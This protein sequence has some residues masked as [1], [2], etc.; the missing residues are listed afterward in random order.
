M[1]DD[2]WFDG[3]NI[4]WEDKNGWF[5]IEDR[6]LDSR[7]TTATLWHRCPNDISSQDDR[8]RIRGHSCHQPDID[9]ECWY[10][11]APLEALTVGFFNLVRYGR[12]Q[13]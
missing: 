12:E 7:G 10:C 13:T 5:I 1:N 2:F 3:D 9:T 8:P 4:L 11:H 6:Y